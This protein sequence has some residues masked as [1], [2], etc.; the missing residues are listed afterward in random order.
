MG[1]DFV[2]MGHPL[3]EHR[4]GLKPVA[5]LFQRQPVKPGLALKLSV[6]QFY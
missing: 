2:V 4:L 6:V 1:T 3:L 5:E